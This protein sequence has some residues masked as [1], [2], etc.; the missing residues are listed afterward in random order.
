MSIRGKLEVILCL[1]VSVSLRCEVMQLDLSSL[2]DARNETAHTYDES[3]AEDVFE[4]AHQ[5]LADGR[6][7]L[8]ALE[9]HND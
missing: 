9:A 2:H 5:F 3:T 4:T 6:K 8:G 1:P 7:L